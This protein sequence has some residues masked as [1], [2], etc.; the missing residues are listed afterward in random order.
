MPRRKYKLNIDFFETIDTHAKAYVLGFIFADGY[1]NLRS[2]EIAQDNSRLDI[3]YKISNVMEYDGGL[4]SYD[5][6]RSRLYLCSR[7]MCKDLLKYG[8]VP[9]KS[10]KLHLPQLEDYLMPSF[11]LGYFDGDGC[12]WQSRREYKWTRDYRNKEKFHW[13]IV[14][15]TKITFTGCLS[16]ISELQNYLIGKLGLTKTK[17]NQFQHNGNKQVA[18]ME[19]S[20]RGTIKKFYDYM[21]AYSPIWCDQKREK[22]LDIF[23]AFEE[24][25][26]IEPPLTAG[27]PLETIKPNTGSNTQCGDSN[28]ISMVK[29]N[30][31]GQSRSQTSYKDEGSSTIP[32]MG[33]ESSD[34]KCGGPY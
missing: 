24:R 14:H 31:I 3:L 21:Y 32:E 27:N 11:I 34:S 23:R 28:Q 18:C 1:N 2:V 12:I 16:F 22:F 4:K 15:N 10:L 29:S 33:V 13:K 6:R 17:L 9:N 19:Y 5:D 30:S 26:S 7:K 25:S 20:G 8:V